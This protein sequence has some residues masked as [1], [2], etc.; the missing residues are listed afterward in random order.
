MDLA[1]QIIANDKTVRNDAVYDLKELNNQ[2]LA[3]QARKRTTSFL[4][5]AIEKAFNLKGDDKVELST[6]NDA[7]KAKLAPTTKNG[8]N[9]LKQNYSNRSTM[10]KEQNQLSPE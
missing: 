1:I 7:L 4:M 9:N 2:S 3:T 10:R 8:L 5:P 6:K